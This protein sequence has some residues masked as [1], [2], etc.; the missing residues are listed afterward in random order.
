MTTKDDQPLPGS[1]ALRATAEAGMKT[2]QA[3]SE[4]LSVAETLRMMHELQVHQIELEMQNE[5]LRRSQLA[6]DQSRTEYVALY[7]TAPIGY[8]TLGASGL[9]MNLNL[10]AAAMLGEVRTALV[11]RPFIRFV[12]PAFG[13][14][15]LENQQAILESGLSHSFDLELTAMSGRQL[16]V[17]LTARAATSADG[18]AVLQVALLD[19][20][21]RKR[22]EEVQAFLAKSA[23]TGSTE[24]TFF[25]ALAHFLSGALDMPYVQIDRL[26]GEN[27][28]ARTMAAHGSSRVDRN[29]TYLLHSTPC[30]SLSGNEIAYLPSR[31]RH[32]FPRDPVL[33]ALHV[34]SYIGIMI[35]SHDGKPLGL[36]SVMSGAP[37]EGNAI[38][39]RAFATKVLAPVAIRVA[40]ELQRLIADD[41]FRMLSLALEQSPET[42]LVTNHL[43]QI[44]FVNDA[45]VKR[46]GYSR[47]EALQRTPRFLQSG[48]TPPKRYA[49]LRKALSQGKQWRGE[50]INRRK[51]GSEYIELAV[52]TPLR[53]WDG[54]VR[55]FVSINVDVSEERRLTAEL[56]QYREM[57]ETLVAERTA[58]L[59]VARNAAET[60]NVAKSAFLMNMSHEIRTVVSQR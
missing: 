33:G 52:I 2:L 50:F 4:A 26:T 16:W 60:A 36:I 47:E 55:R 20:T 39:T 38:A 9:I 22:I 31:A 51:D 13:Q 28:M 8:L 24:R 57:L 58:D 19:I 14:Q 45:F 18:S 46:T 27:L 48:K 59:L 53:D 10:T 5:E 3:P 29:F 40:A 43:A 15:F 1:D 54:V 42:V 41:D 49:E 6:L 7:D 56:T 44:E 35:R 17:S 37:L 23:S 12:I 32:S 21:E 34:E 25:S 11:K 30:G